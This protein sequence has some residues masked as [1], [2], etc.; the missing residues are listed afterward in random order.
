LLEAARRLAASI[1]HPALPRLHAVL[2]SAWGPM[3]VYDW[4]PGE[5]LHAPSAQRGDPANAHQRFRR[6]PVSQ[7]AAALDVVLDAHVALCAAGWIACDF[8]DGAMIY[9]A[10]RRL[11]PLRPRS[12]KRRIILREIF[13]CGLAW[14]ANRRFRPGV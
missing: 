4:V 8:Y 12:L 9:F 10:G 1:D 13:A 2:A 11:S 3:L 5:L 14:P 7:V 6:L